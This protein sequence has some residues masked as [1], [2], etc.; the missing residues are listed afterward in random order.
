M[1]T[2]ALTFVELVFT[3]GTFPISES[4]KGFEE[5]AAAAEE[6]K[7]HVFFPL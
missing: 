3:A 5:E 6:K 2:K 4:F 7:N 1:N